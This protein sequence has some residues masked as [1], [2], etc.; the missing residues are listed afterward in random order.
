MANVAISSGGGEGSRYSLLRVA[1]GILL[2]LVTLM[3]A[4]GPA[5]A[6]RE[7]F[8]MDPGWRFALGDQPGA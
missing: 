3:A 4:A 2:G 5:T 1:M 8:S 6:Q 7:R